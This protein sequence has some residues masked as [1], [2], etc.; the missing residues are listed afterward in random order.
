[1]AVVREFRWT[2]VAIV[3]A[4]LLG[5][6]LYAITPH[7]ELGGAPPSLMTSL[8]AAWMALF[9]EQTLT[10]PQTWYLAL[11][12]GV[13]ALL[14][15]VLIGEGIV[16][17]ALLMLS[18]EHG[19]RWWMKVMASVFRD[20]VVVCGLGHFGY[21]VLGHLVANRVPAVAIERDPD[22]RFLSRA[23]DLG[24][25]VLLR[26]MREDQALV[27]AGV[28]HAR[29]IIIATNDDLVNLEVALDAR[30]LNPRIR[31]LMRL[32]NQQ[33]APKLTS[34]FGLDAAFSSSALAAPA[35]ADGPRH[36]RDRH[37]RDRRRPARHPRADGRE[38]ERA[39]RCRDRRRGGGARRARA[40]PDPAGRRCRVGAPRGH[41]PRAR[42]RPGRVHRRVWHPV[43]RGGRPR[44]AAGVTRAAPPCPRSRP[45]VSRAAP[46]PEWCC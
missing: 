20:H 23:K 27:D 39:P 36:A 4:V 1:V 33:I 8:Y 16:R 25:P 18:R 6:A 15:F 34:T 31:I 30:R 19:E 45:R 28:P 43:P 24:A 26:D 38:R 17:F 11:L 21:R 35:V 44:R 12:N 14:G 29:A 37:P 41:G 5:G 46:R 22:S 42:R 3:A 10:P 7:A 40:R 32:F 13:Y 9:A 2:L